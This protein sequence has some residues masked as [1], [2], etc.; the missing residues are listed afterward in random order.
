MR[1]F[2]VQANYYQQFDADFDLDVPG[3]GYGGWKKA[4]VN[5]SLDHTAVV[6]MHAW[7]CGTREQYPGWYRAVEYIPRADET[8]R[9]VFPGLLNAIR[10]SDLKLFHVV[11]SGEYYKKYSGYHRATQLTRNSPQPIE[12]VD[13]DPTLENLRKFRTENVFVGS[14][15]SP[16]VRCGFENLDFPEAAE[17]VGDEGIAEN[18]DQL[19]ALCQADGVNH[20]IYA[21]FAINWCLLLSP[22]GMA[23]MH[24]R[25]I[26]CSAFRQAVTAVE[27]KETARNE[28]CKEIGLWRVALAY[29]FVFD[30]DDFV[31]GCSNHAR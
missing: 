14:H 9:T 10:E 8:C 11:S 23:E 18:S 12:K 25:G 24:K 30:V 31:F 13:S 1:V 4:I 5:L 7:D 27:N 22:G 2:P 16:D 21:G 3:E 26:M 19:F 20:L 29:G 6:V 15:N 17:P 28:T